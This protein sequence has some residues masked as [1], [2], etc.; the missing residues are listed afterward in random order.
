MKYR[1]YSFEIVTVH[2][3]ATLSGSIYNSWED[4][5]SKES[6]NDEVNRGEHATANPSLRLNPMIHDSIPVL[7]S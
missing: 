5:V 6:E 2:F 4:T 7:T 3:C 1:I